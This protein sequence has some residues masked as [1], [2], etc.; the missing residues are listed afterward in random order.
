M[1]K[2]PTYDD[3]VVDIYLKTGT[4]IKE[5][6]ISTP[7]FTGGFV[8][9]IINNEVWFL[10]VDQVDRVVLYNRGERSE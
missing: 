10:P 7:F 3:A 6:D 9:Y 2:N 5:V 4:I 1:I 8:T